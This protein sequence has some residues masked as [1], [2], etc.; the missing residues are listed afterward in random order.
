[1]MRRFMRQA[2]SNGAKTRGDDLAFVALNFFHSRCGGEVIEA[3][4][5]EGLPL[6][7]RLPAPTRRSSV[8]GAPWRFG[9]GVIFPALGDAGREHPPSKPRGWASDYFARCGVHRV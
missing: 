8:P 2:K 3:R 1:M 5:G 6:G 7:W 9:L 4:L